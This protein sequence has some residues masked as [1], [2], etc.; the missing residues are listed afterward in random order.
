MANRFKDYH[1]KIK[2]NKST[3][4]SD[5][6]LKLYSRTSNNEGISHDHKEWE[7]NYIRPIAIIDEDAPETPDNA[8]KEKTIIRNMEREQKVKETQSQESEEE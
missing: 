3:I 6:E 1:A 7:S 4:L 8:D 2:S 5:E